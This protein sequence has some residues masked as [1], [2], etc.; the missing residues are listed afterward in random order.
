MSVRHSTS[1]LKCTFKNL[2]LFV[3]PF[4]FFFFHLLYFRII[5]VY[6]SESGN[7]VLIACQDTA[8]VLTYDAAKVA[9]ALATGKVSEQEGVEGSFELLYELNETITSGKWVGDCFL[10]CNNSGK[11]NYSVG[12]QVQNLQ[13]LETGP[14]GATKHSIL[15]YLTKEDRVYL[16]DKSLNVTSYKVMLAVLQYQTAVMRGD[17]DTAN[18]LLPSIPESEYTSV[19]KFLESQGFKEEA[20]AVTTDHDHKFDLALELGMISV[21]HEL[22]LDTPEEDKNMIETM[23]KWK[24]LSDAAMKES[25]FELCEAASIASDDYPGLLLLYSSLGNL[26]GMERLAVM[27]A[28]GGK[29]N[30]AFLA[31]LILGKVEA[32]CDLLLATKRFPEAAFFARTY[33]PSRVSETVSLWKN[34]LAKVSDDAAKALADPIINPEMF[35]DYNIALQVE[36]MFMAQREAT[37]NT[38]IPASDYLTAKDD[39]NLDL[40]ALIKE[41]T[42]EKNSEIQVNRKKEEEIVTHDEPMDAKDVIPVTPMEEVVEKL[43]SYT[44]ESEDIPAYAEEEIAEETK[45]SQDDFGEDW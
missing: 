43:E 42:V 13:H 32:C 34:E 20:M 7:L 28:D 18:E 31:N 39:L 15:G 37:F 3:T 9:S 40:I 19:A 23:T 41:R 16:I 11:L 29:T 25:D 5:Q 2:H 10:Y 8:Y 12:G 26:E 33:L 21:A 27:A 35:P 1:R 38:G 30:V 45:N 24:R 36:K 22:L 17:F 14:S 6:W 44:I 4:K